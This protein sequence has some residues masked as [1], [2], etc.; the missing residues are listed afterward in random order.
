MDLY[1][2]YRQQLEAMQKASGSAPASKVAMERVLG[3]SAVAASDGL[4]C[5]DPAKR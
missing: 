1:F 5:E 4:V 3:K 2:M